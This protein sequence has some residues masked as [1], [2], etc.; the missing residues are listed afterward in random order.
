MRLDALDDKR[1]PQRKKM[2]LVRK[3][4]RFGPYMTVDV[5]AKKC[6][7]AGDLNACGTTF[8]DVWGCVRKASVGFLAK[9]A[10]E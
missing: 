5:I 3:L 8:A 10:P 1:S 7:W 2:H 9:T 4:E 6:R